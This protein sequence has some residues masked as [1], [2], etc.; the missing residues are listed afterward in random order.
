MECL[1]TSH[2]EDVWAREHSAHY[3]RLKWFSSVIS[4]NPAICDHN[5]GDGVRCGRPCL[6]PGTPAVVESCSS[7]LSCC[8]QPLR[9]S[10]LRC[11]YHVKLTCLCQYGNF[12]AA[13]DQVVRNNVALIPDKHPGGEAVPVRP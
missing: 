3:G 2:P 5:R 9:I 11:N 6:V 10:W 4:G 13:V 7:D 1:S 8:R 12:L